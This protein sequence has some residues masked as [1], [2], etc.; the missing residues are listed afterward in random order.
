[1]RIQAA[2]F[3][4][5]GAL[6]EGVFASAI[7]TSTVPAKA[8]TF[9]RITEQN[10][11]LIAL[12]GEIMLGDAEKFRDLLSQSGGINAVKLDSPGGNLVASIALAKLAR[13]QGLS[14]I[15]GPN[16]VCASSCV[17][18]FAA[19]REK[20]ADRESFIGVHGV[21]DKGGEETPDARAATL[22]FARY[23][24]DLGAPPSVIHKLVSTP[25]YEIVALTLADLRGMGATITG[26]PVQAVRG[27]LHPQHPGAVSDVIRI[28]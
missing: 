10:Q 1:M 9:V 11:T 17:L 21:A 28:Y 3:A 20:F 14:T 6:L 22:A 2:T 18:I 5:M 15:I 4:L 26:R 25:P 24:R 12:T 16:A 13:S 7:L 23:V 19:G 8:A 27:G